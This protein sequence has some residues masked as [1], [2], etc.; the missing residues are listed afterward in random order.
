[1]NEVQIF[2]NLEGQNGPSEEDGYSIFKQQRYLVI[3]KENG[4]RNEQKPYKN[5]MYWRRMGGRKEQ[6]LCK[7][8]M[9]WS[10]F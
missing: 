9:Y 1:M 8:H 6:N 3:Q 7:K 10:S 2:L 5:H 4:G